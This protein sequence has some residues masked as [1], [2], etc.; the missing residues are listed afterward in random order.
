MHYQRVVCSIVGRAVWKQTL[1]LRFSVTPLPHI[2]IGGR[3]ETP[4]HLILGGFHGGT[5]TPEEP[6][7]RRPEQFR[8]EEPQ[9]KH[10]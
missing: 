6:A 8:G 10:A 5:L 7:Q 9:E 3:L 1:L 2:R 4:T